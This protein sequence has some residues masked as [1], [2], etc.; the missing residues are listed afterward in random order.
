MRRKTHLFNFSAAKAGPE[1]SRPELRRGHHHEASSAGRLILP[2]LAAIL[3]M[4]SAP[5]MGRTQPPCPT[6][7]GDC[8]TWTQITVTTSMDGT[9][10]NGPDSGL[11]TSGLSPTCCLSITFCYEC[12]NGVVETYLEQVL[13]VSAGCAGVTPDQFID[14]ADW[15]AT[16]WSINEYMGGGGAC[17]VKNNPCPGSHLVVETFTPHCWEL[18]NIVGNGVYVWCGDDGCYCQT[19]YNACWDGTKIEYSNYVQ[20]T[21][22]AC[23]CTPE[24]IPPAPW[25][26]MTCYS[27]PCPDG[28]GGHQ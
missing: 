6:L 1:H 11:C 3:I 13:P 18:N 4:A 2:M 22:G 26:P 20:F 7:P 5:R 14:F 9:P 19:D 17:D 8:N 25:I 10:L 16:V 21:V 28:K 23:A 15:Y 24:P 12:C 27:I